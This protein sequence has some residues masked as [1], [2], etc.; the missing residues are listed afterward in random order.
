MPFTDKASYVAWRSTWRAAYAQLSQDIRDV[1][2]A[3][4]YSQI[5]HPRTAENDARFDAVAPKCCWKG[6]KG[7][8]LPHWVLQGL[9][10]D[11]RS[12]LAQRADSKVHAQLLYEAA[13]AASEK[14]AA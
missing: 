12:M 11:A 4:R 5:A 9:K 2:F 10:A 1:K 14:K 7:S 8:F 6:Q 3:V 13:N